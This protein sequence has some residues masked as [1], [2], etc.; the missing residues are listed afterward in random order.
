[1]P[2]APESRETADPALSCGDSQVPGRW[3]LEPHG[4]TQS[5]AH[6]LPRSH[7]LDPSVSLRHIIDGAAAVTETYVTSTPLLLMPPSTYSSG[8]TPCPTTLG[9]TVMTL[10][11]FPHLSQVDAELTPVL[12]FCPQQKAGAVL[13][14]R[15]ARRTFPLTCHRAREKPGLLT[16][17]WPEVGS[18][19]DVPRTC[20]RDRA[21][22][23]PQR[24]GTAAV[25]G[26]PA[27]GTPAPRGP[28]QPL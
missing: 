3:C 23:E 16:P 21:L 24:Q 19:E 8:L 18:G 2:F 22:T 27:G 15:T 11:A 26:P 20:F 10:L 12:V 14:T 1:M 7:T 6:R 4:P 17:V 28:R 13:L 25:H 5:P 9:W